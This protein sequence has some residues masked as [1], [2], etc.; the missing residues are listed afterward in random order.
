MA[1][2]NSQSLQ[3]LVDGALDWTA[4]NLESCDPFINGP[5]PDVLRSKAMAEL[6]FMCDY[7][8]RAA[9]GI[10][11]QRVQKCVS[12]LQA[13]WLR[14][15]YKELIVRNPE[16]LQLYVLAYNS[17]VSCGMEDG[18]YRE[19]I[20]RV[21]DHG[22]ATAVEAV[23]FRLLDLRHVL[24]YGGFQHNLG[25]YDQLYQPTLLAR[26]PPVVYLTDGDVYCLTHTLFYLADFGFK[27][28]DKALEKQMET[29]CW[30]VGTLLGIYL[31]VR[32]WDLVAELLL[33][34]LCLRW[35]PPVVFEAAW[36]SLLRAQLADGYIPAP[37]FSLDR[38]KELNEK[39]WSTYCFEENYHTTLVA[40]LAAFLSDRWLKNP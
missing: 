40:A 21:V 3:L 5:K 34:C 20:Q 32:D 29:I 15:D 38:R 1:T 6:A 4:H 13:V 28:V 16:S 14:P 37:K 8:R 7:Y 24:D 11:D 30:M 35:K 22:Y 19:V 27:P 39:Q 10:R 12:F 2:I 26:M 17:L 25:A 23:P 36:D 9:E 33:C 31:R 18:S